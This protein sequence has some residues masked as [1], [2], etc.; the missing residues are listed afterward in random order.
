MVSSFSRDKVN[1]ANNND[2]EWLFP[3]LSFLSS[4]HGCNRPKKWYIHFI[5]FPLPLQDIPVKTREFHTL[6]RHACYAPALD[7]LQIVTQKMALVI[8]VAQVPKVHTVRD[9]SEGYLTHLIA[10]AV[11]LDSLGWLLS[12]ADVKVMRFWPLFL[13]AVAKVLWIF[14]VDWMIMASAEHNLFQRGVI[15]VIWII[16]QTVHLGTLAFSI[17]ERNFSIGVKCYM[18]VCF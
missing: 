9:A 6:A 7:D 4:S 1:T 5:Y 11:Y 15:R 10:H 17:S 13:R 16:S 18:H 8:T 14:H 12:L 2:D 3:K